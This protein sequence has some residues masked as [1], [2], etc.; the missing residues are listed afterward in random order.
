[1]EAAIQHTSDTFSFKRF[2]EYF[3]FYVMSNRRK[4]ILGSALVVIITFLFILFLLYSGGMDSYRDHFRWNNFYRDYDPFWG[5]SQGAS[6]ML[7][8]L[9]MALAGAMMYGSVARK[10]ERLNTIELPAS[11][12]EKFL[13]WWVIYVPM[14]LAVILCSL[15]VVEVLRV[16]WMH[17][18]TPFGGFA[19]IMPLKDLWSFSLPSMEILEPDMSGMVAFVAYC[20]L[21]FCS[22]LFALGSILFHKISFIKTVVAGFVLGVIYSFVYI[23]G[24]A[25][26]LGEVYEAVEERYDIGFSNDSYLLFGIFLL[27]G[28]GVYLLSYVRYRED[29]IINRW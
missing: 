24:K 20:M 16:V 12:T 14:A 2:R 13:T 19:K 21:I 11:Q 6:L 1:M 17:L 3:T 28:I 15:W 7:T 18:F 4:L 27:L 26:F 9:F 22:S 23:I 25:A 10:K 8:F 5:Y 29:D